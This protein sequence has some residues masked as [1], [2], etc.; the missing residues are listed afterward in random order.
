MSVAIAGHLAASVVVSLFQIKVVWEIIIYGLFAVIWVLS[1]MVIS[2]TGINVHVPFSLA[3]IYNDLPGIR[4]HATMPFTSILI[5]IV[6]GIAMVWTYSPLSDN[7]VAALKGVPTLNWIA[8][9]AVLIAS[10]VVL[11][12]ANL[13]SEPWD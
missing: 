13:L 9:I 7:W 1:T 3:A 6:S 11:P 12:I 2:N 10:L 8:A 4:G 5:C